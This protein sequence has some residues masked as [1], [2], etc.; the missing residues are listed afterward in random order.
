VISFLGTNLTVSGWGQTQSG[1]AS[2]VLKA[3]FLSGMTNQN[4]AAALRLPSTFFG[5]YHICANGLV[6][7]SS[8]CFGDSG[9]TIF[10]FGN[11]I[12]VPQFL[13]SHNIIA[14]ILKITCT[15]P[16]LLFL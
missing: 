8:I 13:A 7:N 6:T 11:Q 15:I 3:T 10:L 5:P 4:C 2:N 12:Y 1:T 16:Y 14:Q 9:G